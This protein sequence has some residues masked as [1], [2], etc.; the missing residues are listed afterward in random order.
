MKNKQIIEYLSETGNVVAL[1]GAWGTGKSHLW[2]NSIKPELKTMGKQVF[3]L[4]L[5]GKTSIADIK[6]ELLNLAIAAASKKE[7]IILGTLSVIFLTVILYVF[8]SQLDFMVHCSI[9]FK[10]KIFLMSLFFSMLVTN[11][12]FSYILK[13]VGQKIIGFDHN[14]IDFL[15]IFKATETVICFDD[16]ERMNYD[17]SV[18]ELLGFVQH[19]SEVGFSVLLILNDK[20]FDRE[21]NE[22]WGRF[23][24]K[25]VKKP[26]PHDFD[27]VLNLVLQDCQARGVIKEFVVFV[28][29]QLN[30]IKTD[31]F[32]K[33][34][35]IL[36]DRFSNNFRFIK[37]LTLELQKIESHTKG[38]AKLEQTAV[39]GILFFVLYMLVKQ[40]IGEL[41]HKPIT[42]EDLFEF[43]YKK[44]ITAQDPNGRKKGFGN[45]FASDFNVVLEVY[46]SIY[47]SFVGQGFDLKVFLQEDIVLPSETEKFS[48]G[49]KHWM[50][51]SLAEQKDIVARFENLFKSEQKPFRS[52]ARMRDVLDKY[53]I[54]CS[55]IN[56]SLTEENTVDLQNKI[57]DFIRD[58]KIKVSL[59]SYGL[60]DLILHREHMTDKDFIDNIRF[61]NRSFGKLLIEYWI[62]EIN[63]NADIISEIEKNPRDAAYTKMCL[64]LFL[65]DKG[66]WD[67]L[68]R[69]REV[70]YSK[71]TGLIRL[72]KNSIDSYDEEY[73]I[74]KVLN[75]ARQDN[76]ARKL[77]FNEKLKMNVLQLLDRPNAGLSERNFVKNLFPEAV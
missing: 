76:H 14:N 75:E 15:Q 62:S 56:K 25:V 10:I 13:F 50:E 28:H 30:N 52:F 2:N 77:E 54:F 36:I 23:R 69:L 20:E 5:F 37:K 46:P 41:V 49:L 17:G 24:E 18:Y 42:T 70:D 26:F 71:W 53:V 44:D 55:Y 7:K 72:L 45:V 59:L 68:F 9:C 33:D 12:Y 73:G 64:Y 66:A 11:R 16:F 58:N 31:S 57:S 34:A 8:L 21:N 67:A 74:V 27:N 48:N 1:I 40:E 19:L 29:K 43:Y 4:S 51:Y 38:F 35:L 39:Q 65:E 61:I 22:V 63:K 60:E 32:S 47:K 6:K 3:S